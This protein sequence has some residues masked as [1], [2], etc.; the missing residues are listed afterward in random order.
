MNKQASTEFSDIS[1][2]TSGKGGYLSKKATTVK[3]TRC[4]LTVVKEG[5]SSEPPCGELRVYFD[6]ST[7]DVNKDGLIYTD[8]LFMKGLE[9]ILA[10]KGVPRGSVDYSE[11]GMQGDDF[12]SC[13]VTGFGA[14]N[15]LRKCGL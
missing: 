3:L 8:P 4:E 11:Q 2:S 13:D 15:A 9:T 14:I 12:V 1:L 6:E 5:S 7:W 10:I